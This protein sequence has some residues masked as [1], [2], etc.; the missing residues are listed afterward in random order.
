MNLQ[1]PEMVFVWFG[2]DLLHVVRVRIL[3]K[4][5]NLSGVIKPTD[6]HQLI[7]NVGFVL[8]HNGGF[9]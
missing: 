7:K 9:N 6:Q 4:D 3:D 1:D 8:T 2:G 5:D